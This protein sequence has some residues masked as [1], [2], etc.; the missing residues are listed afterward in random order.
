MRAAEDVVEWAVKIPGWAAIPG[1]LA[2][3]AA[4]VTFMGAIWDIGV[5][6]DKG[7]DTGP[8]GTTAHYPLLVGLVATYLMGVLAVGMTPKR[9]ARSSANGIELP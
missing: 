3:G 1:L 2:I 5:H 7:R 8:F 6:I 9:R 4:V